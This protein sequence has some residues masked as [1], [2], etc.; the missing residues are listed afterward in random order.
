MYELRTTDVGKSKE[1]FT[2]KKTS[3]FFASIQFGVRVVER[4]KIEAH[5][6]QY[7]D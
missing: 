1:A 3:I 4:I 6:L 2:Y 7:V 5:F